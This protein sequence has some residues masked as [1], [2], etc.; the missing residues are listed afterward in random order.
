M[1]LR[2]LSLSMSCLV[3]NLHIHLILLCCLSILNSGFTT[4]I[5]RSR[6]MGNETDRL[7]LLAIKAKIVDDPLHVLSSWND[8]I[9][10][11]Q[12][13]GIICGRR[14]QRVIALDLQSR[15]L[16]GSI[17]PHLGNLSFLR[18]LQLQNNSFGNEIPP[19]IGRLPRLKILLLNN[20]SVGG[21][22]PVNLSRCANLISLDFSYNGLVEEVP[23]ELG[24]LSKLK[25]VILSNNNL[26]G[27][28]SPFAN[29][30]SLFILFLANNYFDGSIPDGFGRL[31]NLQELELG[32][33]RLS[34]T[35]PP[36]LFNHSSLTAFDVTINQI[37]GS[38]PWDLGITLPNLEFFNIGH[39]HFTGSIPVSISNA[40]K[41]HQLFLLQNKLTGKVPNLER[42]QNLR[43]LCIWDNQLGSGEA[44]DLSFKFSLINATNLQRLE[45]SMNNFGGKLPEYIGNLSR[46]LEYLFVDHNQIFGS[47][48]P[49]IANLVGLQSLLM[50]VNQLTGTIPSGIGKLQN[51]HLLNLIKNSLSGNIPSSLGN[52]SLLIGLM[53]ESNNFQGNIPPSLGNCRTLQFLFLSQNNLNGTIPKQ[54][55]SI[56][57]LSMYL[58][59]SQNQLSGSLPMEVAKLINLGYLDVSKNLL[60]GEIPSTLS[61]CTSLETLRLG[62]NFFNGTIPSSLSFLRGLSELD[63]ANNSLSGEIPAY[64]ESF[65]LLQNLN[66]SFNNFEGVVPTQ[67]VFSNA[68]AI[69]VVGNSKLCGGVVELKLPKCN[70]QVDEKRRSNSALT[71]ALSIPFG[72]VGLALLGYVLYLF[73]FRK[74]RKDIPS[75]SIKNSLLRVSYQTLV[76]ATDGFSSFNLIGVG[77][78]GSVYK[79]VIDGRIV[80]IKVLN[81]LRHGASKSFVSEC[82]ALR[83][84]RHRNLVKVLTACSTVDYQ[85]HDFKAL[86]YEFMVNGSLEEWLH[87]TCNEDL[88]NEEFRKL[89]LFQRLNIVIDIVCALNYL[90]NHGQTPIIHCDLKPSNILL[91]KDMTGHVGDFGIVK[92]LADHATHDLS[93]NETSS[94]GIRGTIGYVAPEYAMGSEVSTYGDIYSFG[95]LVLE[96]FTGKRPTNEMFKDGLSLHSFVNKALPDSVLKISDPILLQTK[97]EEETFI[98]SEKIVECLSWILEIGVNCS[99]ELPRERMCINDVLAKLHFIK[100]TLLGSEIS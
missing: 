62:N 96:M 66:L 16:V 49:G 74:R 65:I 25:T 71:L 94:I 34:G 55:V 72:L 56:S 93:A 81:L 42:L 60:S 47:I 26:T 19:D 58:D 14:H 10:F 29:L 50:Q 95:I 84:I 18:E 92:F 44:D 53:L 88:S 87:P 9:H 77:S 43:W 83:N 32:I 21:R 11:C 5:S 61:S 67:G 37:Q 86:V 89:N 45:V 3:H 64:L 40:S 59:L 82:E 79:G 36:S 52:L 51:L 99:S 2:S 33:N 4:T 41:L 80:A 27:S 85:G 31:K 23:V 54:V 30:S 75:D 6:L 70:F 69:S 8:S 78:F 91:D 46:N 57:S 12:W 73:R 97:E 20:N 35:I 7:S 1:G 28:I 38:L 90:H 100:D 48:P 39:N 63:L 76:K 15:E 24:S 98:R 22:I 13:Q 17:S 68:S